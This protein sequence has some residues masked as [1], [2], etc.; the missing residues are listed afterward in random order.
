MEVAFFSDSYLPTRDGVSIEVSALA[1]ELHRRGHGVTVF[2]PHPHVGA[3]SVDE[4]VD[5]IRIVRCRSVP[6]PLYAQYRWALFPFTKVAGRDFGSSVDVVHA[7]TPGFLGTAAF[8][9]ARRYHLPLVGTFHTDVDAARENFGMW[10]PI[11]LFLWAATRYSLG[12][13]W[14]CDVATAPSVPARDRLLELA[15]RPFRHPIEVVPNGIEIHRFRRGLVVPDWRARCGFGEVPLLTYLG[16]LTRDKGIHRFLDALAE[17]PPAR[18]WCGVIAGSGPEE[19]SVRERLRDNPELRA[20]VRFLGPVL[21]EEKPALLSQSDLFVLPSTSDTS[22][23]AVLEA[24]ASGAA[25]VVSN[26]G[27]PASIVEDGRTGRIVPVE[28]DRALPRAL[29]ELVEDP[30]ERTRLGRSGAEWV[31]REASIEVTARRFISLYE[32]L[33]SRG[34]SRSAARG[35]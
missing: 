24:M 21:E 7:H 25:C 2:A 31:R 15:S 3:P 29:L 30:V 23:V 5:G 27:G 13:Y 26:V 9:A 10:N 8:F 35:S 19:A 34:G 18:E 12:I 6:V 17:L 11:R 33:R 1:R 16:R 32:L 4:A 28:S 20:R 14:R 22:S